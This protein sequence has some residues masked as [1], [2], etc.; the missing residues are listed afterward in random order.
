MSEYLRIVVSNLVG[1]TVT[2]EDERGYYPE[3]ERVTKDGGL[4]IRQAG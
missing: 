4:D 1:A 2:W 3:T